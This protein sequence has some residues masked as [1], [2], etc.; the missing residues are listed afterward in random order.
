MTWR[1]IT[2]SK[3]VTNGLDIALIPLNDVIRFVILQF[4]INDLPELLHKTSKSIS[5]GT[6][7]VHIRNYADMDW[8]DKSWA[9]NVKGSELEEGEMFLVHDV[10]GKVIIKESIF[11]KI[12]FDYSSKALEVYQS[13]TLLSESWKED[14]IVALEKLKAKIDCNTVQ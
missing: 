2:N 8:E 14:M 1:I 10:M 13:D 5:T 11:D 4:N 7:Y 6:E 12:L 9:K 3:E